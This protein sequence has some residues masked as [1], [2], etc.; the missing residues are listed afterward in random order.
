MIKMKLQETIN[1]LEATINKLEEQFQHLDQKESFKIYIRGDKM[2]LRVLKELKASG[3]SD[4]EFT[5]EWESRN[6]SIC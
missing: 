3:I 2:L 5:R 1:N 6:E 4:E